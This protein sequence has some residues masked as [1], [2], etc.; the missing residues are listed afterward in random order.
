MGA[1]FTL[2][3]FFIYGWFSLLMKQKRCVCVFVRER[4]SEQKKSIQTKV[5]Y[6]VFKNLEH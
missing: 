1:L 4:E 3:S 5:G 2:L 6:I